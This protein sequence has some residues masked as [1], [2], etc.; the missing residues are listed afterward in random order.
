M[1]FE[2][3]CLKL[4]ESC[5]NGILG[6][7]IITSGFR[8]PFNRPLKQMGKEC[9]SSMSSRSVWGGELCDETQNGCEG[10]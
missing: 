6:T 2:R 3:A 1:R 9:A 7:C 5:K 4:A 8:R 10:D